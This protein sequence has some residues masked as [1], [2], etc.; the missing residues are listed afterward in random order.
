MGVQFQWFSVR[1]AWSTIASGADNLTTLVTA[2]DASTIRRIIYDYQV[3]ISAPAD[4]TRVTG[5][6]G[7]IVADAPAIA[8]GV[9]SLAKPFSQGDQEWLFTRGYGL[10]IETLADSGGM[11]A[12]ATG[13]GDIRTMRKLKQND[14]VA[15]VIENLAGNTIDF[16]M[17]GRILFSQ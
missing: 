6:F 2:A 14:A 12:G 5:M 16:C 10:A 8:A 3:V 4:G 15:L 13:H 9:A 17:Q 11:L 1:R 7:M